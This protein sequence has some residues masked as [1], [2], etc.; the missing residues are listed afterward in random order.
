MTNKDEFKFHFIRAISCLL[1]FTSHYGAWH[2][3]IHF[4]R[5][6]AIGISMF[7]W[8]SGYLLANRYDKF[9]FGYYKKRFLRI[10]PTVFIVTSLAIVYL[11]FFTNNKLTLDILLIFA[12]GS[13]VIFPHASFAEIGGGMWFVSFILITYLILPVVKKIMRNNGELYLGLV[14]IGVGIWVVFLRSFPET[15]LYVLFYESFVWFVM[16][17]FFSQ[18]SKYNKGLSITL[19]TWII[20]SLSWGGFLY[21]HFYFKSLIVQYVS[22]V[23]IP[24][25]AFPFLSVISNIVGN[26]EW[27]KKTLVFI[28]AIS[29]E[30]YLVHFYI[31][32]KQYQPVLDVLNL[33]KLLYLLYCF[34][35]TVTFATIAHYFSIRI[36][37]LINTGNV[38]T[39]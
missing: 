22:L 17:V 16:G 38:R 6:T 18:N 37:T 36:I 32:P 2:K 8:M 28:S 10:Y 1:V 35:L 27:L 11:C 4:P 12:G 33:G 19:F 23:M 24:L 30:I 31:V 7:A 25:W 26:C 34:L 39:P 20:F 5:G 13:R 29:F 3:F 14:I 21:Y 15:R 9:D